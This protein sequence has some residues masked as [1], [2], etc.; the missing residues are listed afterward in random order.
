MV[1]P[2]HETQIN[3]ISVL[4]ADP[5]GISGFAVCGVNKLTSPLLAG[6]SSIIQ[7]GKY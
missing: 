6:V 4:I 7:P 5:L 2:F 1:I 3:E